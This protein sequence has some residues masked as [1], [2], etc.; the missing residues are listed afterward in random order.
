[1]G[2]RGA[3]GVVVLDDQ[4]GAIAG[5]I[6]LDSRSE[7]RDDPMKYGVPRS[8]EMPRRFVP[9]HDVAVELA[10]VPMSS[11]RGRSRRH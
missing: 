9:E 5:R 4:A 3:V 10:K 2:F 6:G 8:D 1:M 11:R 7:D